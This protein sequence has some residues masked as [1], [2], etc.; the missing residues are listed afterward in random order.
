MFCDIRLFIF[1]VFVVLY[2]FVAIARA[3]SSFAANDGHS[4]ATAATAGTAGDSICSFTAHVDLP[5][6]QDIEQLILQRK[7]RQL[8]EKY[9]K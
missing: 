9:G 7:K 8:L 6:Q 5:S 2:L 1:S 4:A 3:L